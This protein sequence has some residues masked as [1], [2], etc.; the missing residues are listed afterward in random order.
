MSDN[1]LQILV[2]S[3]LSA[4]ALFVI[5]E[6]YTAFKHS[7]SDYIKALQQN[8]LAIQALQIEMKHIYDKLGLI[9]QM[10]ADIYDAHSAIREVRSQLGSR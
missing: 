9:P 3:N 5:K 1:Q 2:I 7:G 8:T 4:L 10:Q 6:V